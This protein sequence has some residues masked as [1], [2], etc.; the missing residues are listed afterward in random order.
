MWK[1]LT[2]KVYFWTKKLALV[3]SIKREIETRSSKFVEPPA[4]FEKAVNVSYSSKVSDNFFSV[5]KKEQLMIDIIS[6]LI[7]IKS[8]LIYQT[9]A[10]N[11]AP[12][13]MFVFLA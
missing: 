13:S 5:N 4:L 6:I 12:D 9:S 8:K 2:W 3:E 7:I 10:K 11:W 1:Y